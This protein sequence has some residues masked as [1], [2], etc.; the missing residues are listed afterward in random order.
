MTGI[1]K[2][3]LL[4]F[5]LSLCAASIIV[6]PPFVRQTHAPAPREL[7]SVVNNQL[8]AFRAADFSRAYRNASTRVQQ[9]FSLPQF[10]NMI[11]RNYSEMIREKQHVEFGVVHAQG[12]SAILQVFFF[13]EGGQAH[14]FLYTF[15]I[16]EGVWKIEGVEPVPVLRSKWVGLHV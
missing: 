5:F 8:T 13:P 2:S 4:L 3:F 16:E 14:A 7:Y 1:V 11:R 15:V 6:T 9:K 10:E 12:R